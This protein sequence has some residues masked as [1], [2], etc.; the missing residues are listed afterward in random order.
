MHSNRKGK[1]KFRKIEITKVDKSTE[2]DVSDTFE[3]SENVDKPIANEKSDEPS[4]PENNE[5]RQL[6]YYS[7]TDQFKIPDVTDM[8]EE[9]EN[10]D[11][12]IETENNE[13]LIVR[14]AGEPEIRQGTL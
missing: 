3:E 12:P 7:I 5:I 1:N 9:F 4:V 2:S 14:M 8:V 11:K 6:N 10:V 13:E